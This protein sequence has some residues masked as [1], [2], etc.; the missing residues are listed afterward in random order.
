MVTL[1]KESHVIME[2]FHLALCLIN[3]TPAS[4]TQPAA[5]AVRPRGEELFS[6]LCCCCVSSWY[7]IETA[8][9][10]MNFNPPSAYFR[11]I[12]QDGGLS[13]HAKK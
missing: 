12:V 11:V 10:N 5:T 8:R 6:T 9:L 2:H 13:K 1:Y 3:V 4:M 7:L